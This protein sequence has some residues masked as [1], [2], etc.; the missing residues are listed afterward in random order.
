MSHVVIGR[1]TLQAKE[2]AC[3][4]ALHY[5]RAM[6]RC[7]WPAGPGAEERKGDGVLLACWEDLGSCSEHNG[8]HSME[9]GLSR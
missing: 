7:R 1:E 2:T 6:K 5:S 4:K 3:A 9:A 8:S